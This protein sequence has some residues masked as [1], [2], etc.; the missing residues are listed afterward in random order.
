LGSR[1]RRSCVSLRL[2]VDWGVVCSILAAW[3]MRKHADEKFII[4]TFACVLFPSFLLFFCFPLLFRTAHLHMKRPRGLVPSV[5]LAVS[6]AIRER[7]FATA[8][9]CARSRTRVAYQK[10]CDNPSEFQ[11]LSSE[12]RR[13]RKGINWGVVPY[14]RKHPQEQKTFPAFIKGTREHSSLQKV[15]SSQ[16]Q[17]SIISTVINLPT[18]QDSARLNLFERKLAI[19]SWEANWCVDES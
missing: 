14:G 6:A 11:T 10:V 8:D 2:W 9:P 5:E 12:T 15:F 1:W 16:S 18:S 3:C 17:S 7:S 13:R 4:R 19:A